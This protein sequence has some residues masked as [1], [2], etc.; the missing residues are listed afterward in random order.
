MPSII[1]INF[2]KVIKQKSRAWDASKRI[3]IV[4]IPEYVARSSGGRRCSK[5]QSLPNALYG[6]SKAK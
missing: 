2:L 3:A 6:L 5:S 4:A 1:I